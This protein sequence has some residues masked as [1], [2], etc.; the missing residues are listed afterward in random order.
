MAHDKVTGRKAT[1]AD[2]VRRFGNWRD[3]ARSGPVFVTHHGRPT[4]VLLDIT[5]YEQLTL[6]A[7]DVPL[8]GGGYD[9]AGG[10]LRAPLDSFIDWLS[11]GAIVCDAAFNILAINRVGWGM[12]GRPAGELVGQLLWDAVPQLAGGLGQTYIV[13]ALQTGEPTSADLPSAL[14]PNNW[15]RLDAFPLAGGVGVVFRD[16]TEEVVQ[17]RLANVKEAI[18][19]AMAV[20]GEIGYMRLA[21][22]GTIERVDAPLSA[23]FGVPEAGLIGAQAIDL[24]AEHARPRFRE[25]LTR[26]MSSGGE[27]RFGSTLINCSGQEQA[28][29]IALVALRGAYGVEGA[30]A[31]VTGLGAPGGD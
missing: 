16:I 6:S 9:P 1:A 29:T 27:A 26:V 30:V 18:L 25:E 21:N 10:P 28:V 4:H 3:M 7:G 8:A 11:Q 2:F 31:I 24:V 14:R 12:V 20:H 19:R 23:L 17:N 15:L 22:I 13:R 5:A